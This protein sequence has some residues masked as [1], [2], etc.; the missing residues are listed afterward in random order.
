MFSPETVQIYLYDGISDANRVNIFDNHEQALA[1]LKRQN[2][3]SIEYISFNGMKY[4]PVDTETIRLMYFMAYQK[5][6]NIITRKHIISNEHF[7]V[8]ESIQIFRDVFT[9]RIKAG[10]RDEQRMLDIAT[11][12]SI[13][14]VILTSELE[15]RLVPNSS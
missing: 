1:F 14:D 5:I 11:N 8:V 10:E 7:W 15:Q 2:I 13:Q 3:L 12:K 6:E 9:V 4:V